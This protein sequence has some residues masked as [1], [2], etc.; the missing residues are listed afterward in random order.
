MLSLFQKFIAPTISS[1]LK[2]YLENSS[3]FSS[4]VFENFNVGNSTLLGMFVSK[5]INFSSHFLE[6]KNL[7]FSSTKLNES[8]FKGL[9]YCAERLLVGQLKVVLDQNKIK[10][11]LD[12]I[13]G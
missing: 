8:F 11:L 4:V 3:Q 7:V 9:P 2:D 5:E 6:L 10:I 12:N 1:F 13:S